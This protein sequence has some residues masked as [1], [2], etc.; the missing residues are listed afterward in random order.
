GLV[1]SRVIP[2]ECVDLSVEGYRCEVGPARGQR[3]NGGPGIGRRVIDVNLVIVA[4]SRITRDHVE[5]AGEPGD[6]ALRVR[7][8]NRGGPCLPNVSRQCSG[9]AETGWW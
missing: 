6:C 2:P 1:R 8:W 9:Q 5:L 3:G 7:I 4:R